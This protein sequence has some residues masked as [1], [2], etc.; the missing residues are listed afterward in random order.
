MPLAP[1][2]RLGVLTAAAV[3]VADQASKAWMMDLLLE[4][5]RAIVIAP[6]FNLVPVWNKGISFGMMQAHEAWAAWGLIGIALAITVTL[7]FWLATSRR[8][9]EAVALG[10]IIGGALGNVADR[11]RFGAVFDFLDVHAAGWHWPAFNVA[12]AGISVGAVF[13]IGLALFGGREH[14]KS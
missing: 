13:L 5:P 2:T 14:R 6:F 4:P 11:V 3:V 1:E 8:P 10:L 7:S 9:A 12:D